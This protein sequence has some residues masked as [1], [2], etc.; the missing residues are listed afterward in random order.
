MQNIRQMNKLGKVIPLRKDKFL[1]ELLAK[2]TPPDNA[3][4]QD[5]DI[6]NDSR[7]KN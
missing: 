1:P 2:K 3:V 7:T 4:P 6:I 5:C